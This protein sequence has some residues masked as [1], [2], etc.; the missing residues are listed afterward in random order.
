MSRRFRT[1]SW[2]LATALTAGSALAQDFARPPGDPTLV[3]DRPYDRDPRH[4]ASDP[5][6]ADGSF[7]HP[8]SSVRFFVGPAL[9][10]GESGTAGGLA[11]AIEAGEGPAGVRLTGQWVEVGSDDGLAQY[12]AELWLDF[13]HG[14]RLHPMLG[15]GAGV[16][17]V[18]DAGSTSTVGVGVLRGTLAYLLPVDGTDA[19]VAFDAQGSLPAIRGNDAPEVA[20][21]LTLSVS[22]GVGF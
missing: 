7:H 4:D 17:R 5:V 8:A 18:E 13:G 20:P 15:A 16:A 19:R 6:V 11:A 12:A 14:R 21:W 10:I 9:R 3:D 2:F 1:L 22:V